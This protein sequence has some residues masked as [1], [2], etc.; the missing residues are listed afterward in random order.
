MRLK[1]IPL[2]RILFCRFLTW[3]KRPNL[4]IFGFN[5]PKFRVSETCLTPG[6]ADELYP[7]QPHAPTTFRQSRPP[8][9]DNLDIECVL[10]HGADRLTSLH[11]C[12]CGGSATSESSVLVLLVWTRGSH[13]CHP[14]TETLFCCFLHKSSWLYLT[15]SASMR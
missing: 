9:A 13:N 1:R 14:P 5:A 4:Q 6:F 7:C 11:S 2:T 8:R 15:D 3:H 10:Q 12:C